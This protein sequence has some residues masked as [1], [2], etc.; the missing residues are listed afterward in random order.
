MVPCVPPKCFY[1]KKKDKC[2]KP[3]PYIETLAWCKRNGIKNHQECRKKYYT[4]RD[5]AKALACERYSERLAYVKPKVHSVVNIAMKNTHMNAKT[6]PRGTRNHTISMKPIKPQFKTSNI[7][8]HIFVRDIYDRK[9]RSSLKVQEKE[10]MRS[11]SSSINTAKIDKAMK[12]LQAM[13][14]KM[15]LKKHLLVKYFSLEKRVKYYKYVKNFLRKLNTTACIKPKQFKNKS[16]SVVQG[17]TIEDI[18]DLER[19]IGTDSVYGVVYKT[20]VK[21]MLGRAPIAT[22][23]MQK[24][25]TGNKNEIEINKRISQNIIGREI[26]RHFLFSYKSF[27]CTNWLDDKDVPSLIK[28]E[29]YFA[30]LYELAHGDVASLCSNKGFLGNEELVINIACQCLLSIATLHKMGLVHRDTHW[31]N[32]LYHIMDN[33]KGYYHYIINGKNYYLKNCGYNVMLCDFGLATSYTA[34]KSSVANEDYRKILEAFQNKNIGAAKWGK[35][36][37]LPNEKVSGFIKNVISHIFRVQGSKN[38]NRFIEEFLIDF[39]NSPIRGI[40]VNVRPPNEKI[41]NDKP[42]IIDENLQKIY[43]HI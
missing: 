1:L 11:E 8:E 13:R 34:D 18:I 14:I 37:S 22:K 6:S 10:A 21:N 31:G 24:Y 30:S 42:F 23:L 26:S 2:V 20:S 39:L 28:N 36:S 3:N 40:L 9:T 4:D 38:E 35:Y 5:N 15:F 19:R 17:Y 29:E 27:E 32:F 43:N 12:K 16:G 41:I 25:D 7:S 33:N